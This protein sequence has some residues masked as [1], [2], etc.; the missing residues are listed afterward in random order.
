MPVKVKVH[1]AQGYGRFGAGGDEIP[2]ATLVMFTE[3]PYPRS[4]KASDIVFLDDATEIEALLH[5]TLP[6]GTY[7]WLLGLMLKRK[8]SHFI[9]PH[10]GHEDAG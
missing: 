10:G 5:A 9:V 8:A 7:D 6:G 1:K 4:V 2:S 3:I